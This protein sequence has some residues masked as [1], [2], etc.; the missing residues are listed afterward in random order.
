[1]IIWQKYRKRKFIGIEQRGGNKNHPQMLDISLTFS[2]FVLSS[3]RKIPLS[4]H[5]YFNMDTHRPSDAS[6][7]TTLI[8]YNFFS[9]ADLTTDVA[10]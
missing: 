8:F 6:T 7:T 10:L 4:S 9:P 2:L 3:K 5:C 1:M